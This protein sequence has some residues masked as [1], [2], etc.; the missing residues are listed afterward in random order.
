MREPVELTFG[1]CVDLLSAGLV[2]RL[3]WATSSGPRIVPLNYALHGQ[4]LL[5]RTS[6]Y[7]ELATY[8]RGTE[9]AFE[10]DHLDYENQ[11]GWSV[12]AYGRLQPADIDEVQDWRKMWDPRPW[13]DGQRH[14]YLKLPFRDLSGRRLGGGWSFETMTPVRR[15]M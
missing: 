9:A 13:A 6:A 10:I 12:V 14:Y 8:G 5:F 11:R 3:A 4:V 7:S 2:G 1:E 15:V